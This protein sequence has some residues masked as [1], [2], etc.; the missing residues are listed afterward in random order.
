V[1]VKLTAGELNA[2][3]SALGERDATAE[4]CV[5]SR[6]ELEPDSELRDTEIVPLK[7]SIEDYFGREVKPHVPDAWIDHAKTKVGYEIPLTRHFYRY[8]PPRPLD[9]IETDLAGLEKRI[10]EMLKDVVA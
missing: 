6:G 2:V 1:G 9:E 3:L 7:E 4:A 8:E 10:V 5:N